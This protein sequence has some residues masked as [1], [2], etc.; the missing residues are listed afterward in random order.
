[1][2]TN[3]SSLLVQFPSLTV[4]DYMDSGRDDDNCV[5]VCTLMGVT[6]IFNRRLLGF[7]LI[8]ISTVKRSR[9]YK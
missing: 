6:E 7:G 1:M 8:T 4:D 2:T 5:Q 9:H 3:K